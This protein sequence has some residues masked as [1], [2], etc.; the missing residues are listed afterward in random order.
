[1]QGP[2]QK[3]PEFLKQIVHVQE[4]WKNRGILAAVSLLEKGQGHG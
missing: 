2:S 3:N 1:M 4:T